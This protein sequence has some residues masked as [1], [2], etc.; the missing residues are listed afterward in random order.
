MLLGASGSHDIGILIELRAKGHKGPPRPAVCG[1]KFVGSQEKL[2]AVNPSSSWQ[3]QSQ[4]SGDI[5]ESRGW[6][7]LS[8]EVPIASG[9]GFVSFFASYI[10]SFSCFPFW[11]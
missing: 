10:I 9:A 7:S 8:L 1:L 2:R 3:L 5:G 6:L 4:P 11:T